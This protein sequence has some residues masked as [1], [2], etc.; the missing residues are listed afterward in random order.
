M[1]IACDRRQARVIMRYISGFLTERPL[2][3]TMVARQS[4]TDS[5]GGWG[6]RAGQP[7]GDRGHTPSFRRVRE[8]RVLARLLDEIAFWPSDEASASPDVEVL[9]AL[10][11]SMA[12]IPGS[13]LLAASSPYSRRG[14]L[15]NVCR[16]HWGKDGPILVWQA[17]TSVMNPT[18]P[19]EVID[20]ALERDQLRAASEWLAEFRSDLE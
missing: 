12:T 15:W 18:V 17:P 9:E 6:F 8:Y 5:D 13:M 16:R 3:A 7:G 2:L 10:R 4:K 19:S 20:A 11:P 1:V 14:A